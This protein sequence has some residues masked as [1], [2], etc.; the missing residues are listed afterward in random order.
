VYGGDYAKL[1]QYENPRN[2]LDLQFSARFLKQRL[3]VK[4]NVSDILNEDM[5]IYR[6]CDYDPTNDQTVDPG[7]Y[8]DRTGLGMDYNEGDWVSSRTNKGVNYSFSV[9]YKF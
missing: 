1:D 8:H 9:S 7:G 5:I 4:F 6:N 2:V 3:E